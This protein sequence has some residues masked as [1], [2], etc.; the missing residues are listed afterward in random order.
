LLCLVIR[1]RQSPIFL[2]ST[3]LG[4]EL[5]ACGENIRAARYARMPYGRLVILVMAAK[6]RPGRMGRMP[7]SLGSYCS[8][9]QPSIMAGYG[10]TAIV[11]AW[12]ARLNP[13][14]IAHRLLSAGGAARRHRKPAIGPAIPAAF[15]GIM[16]GVDSSDGTGWQLLF[17]I[18]ACSWRGL[19]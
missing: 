1:V 4:Y 13:V 5:K 18:T 12:L 2:R 10:Y 19:G 7:G 9:L 17:P 6:R 15:G 16:E 14:N 8:R 3:R 11:V